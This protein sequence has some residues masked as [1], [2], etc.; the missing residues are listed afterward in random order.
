MR[1]ELRKSEWINERM[2][3]LLAELFCP[4][5]GLHNKL[6]ND[7]ACGMRYLPEESYE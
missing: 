2:R 7:D 5:C 4:R 3:A 1:R 6:H